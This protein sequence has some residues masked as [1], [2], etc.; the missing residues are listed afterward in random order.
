MFGEVRRDGRLEPGG[1]IGHGV[2]VGVPL[3]TLV[4]LCSGEDG[5][6]LIIFFTF[7]WIRDTSFDFSPRLA[8]AGGTVVVV[9]CVG[10][11]EGDSPRISLTPRSTTFFRRPRVVRHAALC[12]G[13]YSGLAFWAAWTGLVIL[14]P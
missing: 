14:P 13:R 11:G 2:R 7:C 9:A 1:A 3:G 8:I 4:V 12:K 6:P 5:L 10:G